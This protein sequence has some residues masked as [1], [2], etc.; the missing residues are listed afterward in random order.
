MAAI[1]E[2]DRDAAGTVERFLR[3]YKIAYEKGLRLLKAPQIWYDSPVP[4]EPKPEVVSLYEVIKK[5]NPQVAE[6]YAQI[7]GK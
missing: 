7:Y 1:D 4:D 5:Y 3:N 2:D 6:Q